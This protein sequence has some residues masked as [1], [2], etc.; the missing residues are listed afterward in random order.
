MRPSAR[1]NS[2]R[3]IRYSDAP[4][5]ISNNQPTADAALQPITAANYTSSDSISSRPSIDPK[6]WLN[7]QPRQ[8]PA[9][10]APVP[11]P[12]AQFR[13]GQLIVAALVRIIQVLLDS[14]SMPATSIGYLDFP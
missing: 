12:G 6:R 5:G 11:Y 4:R 14:S 3:G 13:P 10:D 1:R 7:Q 8:A 2:Q 9:A